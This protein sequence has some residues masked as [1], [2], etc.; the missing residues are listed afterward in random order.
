LL[1][2]DNTAI[3]GAGVMT[4]S[5]VVLTACTVMRNLA[6]SG[7]GASVVGEGTLTSVSTD[8][9]D[10]ADDNQPSDVFAGSEI[11]GYGDDTSFECTSTGCTP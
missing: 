6:A 9:G 1:V 4:E 2:A 7:G 5:P 8:W 10:E 3:N 11:G